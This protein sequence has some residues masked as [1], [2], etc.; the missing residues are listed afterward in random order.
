MFMKICKINYQN[1]LNNLGF[2][3][4]SLIPFYFFNEIWGCH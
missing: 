4:E 1:A 3:D 2:G